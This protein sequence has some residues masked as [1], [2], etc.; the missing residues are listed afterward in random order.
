MLYINSPGD[1]MYAIIVFLLMMIIPILSI[2]VERVL[3]SSALPFIPL[4]GKWFVFWAVGVRLITASYKQVFSPEFTAKE[5]FGVMEKGSEAI[6]KELGF[7][8]FS[9]GLLGVCSLFIPEWRLPAAIAGGL[10]FGFSGFGHWV[11]KNI[12][13]NE[14]LS[15]LSDFWIFLICIVYCVYMI[16]L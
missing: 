13:R 2:I 7:A 6:V 14:T 1:A 4:I 5:V 9:L 11:R 12:N 15:M 16:M 8:N 10:F 3:F